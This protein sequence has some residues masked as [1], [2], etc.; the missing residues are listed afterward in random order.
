M[1]VRK[2]LWYCCRIHLNR[3]LPKRL[4]D[5]YVVLSSKTV[6]IYLL[7]VIKFWIFE[8]TIV[9]ANSIQYTQREEWWKARSRVWLNELLSGGVIVNSQNTRLALQKH[10]WR[11]LL[12]NSN[13]KR[14]TY[15]ENQNITLNFTNTGI[16]HRKLRA[17]DGQSQT[18][19]VFWPPRRKE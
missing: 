19:T 8:F 5:C 17:D 12:I 11:I 3:L 18:R 2:L 15:Y 9:A 7:L 10:L 6:Q 14:Y 4:S 16:F 13:D 1:T